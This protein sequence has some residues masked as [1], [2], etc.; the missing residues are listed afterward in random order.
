[1]WTPD[2]SQ[3]TAIECLSVWTPTPSAPAFSAAV[4][5]TRNRLRGST[6]APRLSTKNV[7]PERVKQLSAEM[8]ELA[9]AS[10]THQAALGWAGSADPNPYGGPPAGYTGNGMPTMKSVGGLGRSQ[11]K[12]TPPSPLHASHD[13]LKQLFDAANHKAG[14]FQIELKTVGAS[15]NS[16]VHTKAAISETGGGFTLPSTI[17]PG[18][19]SIALTNLIGCSRISTA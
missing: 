2:S 17:Q 11:P 5:T 6:A 15:G 7:S 18:L 8:D 10:K 13:E 12:W 1:M 19:Q 14:G 3:P 4:S 16:D 9:I